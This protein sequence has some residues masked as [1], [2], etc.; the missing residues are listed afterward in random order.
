MS[1]NTLSNHLSTAPPSVFIKINASLTTI[2]TIRCSIQL[3]D[4]RTG[5]DVCSH[6]IRLTG[7]NI[8]RHKPNSHFL[9]GKRKES[10]AA[11]VTH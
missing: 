5:L 7:G 3:I 6:I 9:V 10:S 1:Q 8:E 2:C 4:S 11:L